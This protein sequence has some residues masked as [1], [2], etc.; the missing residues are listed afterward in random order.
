MEIRTL[1]HKSVTLF[2]KQAPS[3]LI[4]AGIFSFFGNGR[5]S[6]AS[7]EVRSSEDSSLYKINM[8]TSG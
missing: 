7:H 1:Q 6:N 8:I 4:G 3:E 5:K 2:L